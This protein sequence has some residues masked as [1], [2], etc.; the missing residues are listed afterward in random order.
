[1]QTAA[2]TRARECLQQLHDVLIVLLHEVGHLRFFLRLAHDLGLD[3]FLNALHEDA[4]SLFLVDAQQQALHQQ[5]VVL[6]HIEH[7][8]L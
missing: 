2:G 8:V 5:D 4:L 6:M 3:R 7:E 1:M